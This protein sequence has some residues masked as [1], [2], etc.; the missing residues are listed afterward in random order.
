MKTR[1]VKE[2]LIIVSVL[3]A[4]VLVY[5]LTNFIKPTKEEQKVDGPNFE[6][7]IINNAG[8]SVSST[9]DYAN[10]IAINVLNNGGNAVDAVIAMSFALGVTSPQNG[11]LGSGGLFLVYSSQEDQA[12]V[13]DFYGSIGYEKSNYNIG[14]PGYLK[15]IDL[16][17][18]DY[19]TKLIE[20]LI[21]PS[22]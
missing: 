16:I 13:Y 4:L 20:E 2:G 21:Q 8:Y 19:G 9:S 1:K 22:I 5:P 18:S 12:F 7:P 17:H 10:E 6:S 11:V 3:V 14:I 15:G